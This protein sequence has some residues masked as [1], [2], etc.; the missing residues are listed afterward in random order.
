[1]KNKTTFFNTILIILT[2]PS[3]IFAQISLSGKVT[4]L[5][6]GNL[7]PTV[8]IKCSN[9]EESHTNPWGEYYFEDLGYGYYNFTFSKPYYAVKTIYN[10]KVGDN[11]ILNVQLSKPCTALKFITDTL[12]PASVGKPY[13]AAL[14][15]NCDTRPFVFQLLDSTTLPQG[16]YLDSQY[17]NISGTPSEEGADPF[18]IGVTDA[19][20]NFTKMEFT[21]TVTREIEFI[22]PDDLPIAMRGEIYREEIQAKHGTLPYVFECI[23]GSL[24]NGLFLSKD[25]KIGGGATIE[26]F[27]DKGLPNNWE[28]GDVSPAISNKNQLLFANLDI[29][30]N[31]VATLRCHTT[32]NAAIEFNYGIVNQ[33][34]TSDYLTF[35]V[36]QVNQG[37]FSG[38]STDYILLEG[39]AEGIHIF[40]WEFTKNSSGSLYSAA[41][42]DNVKIQGMNAVP[43]ETGPSNFTIRVTDT[44]G[45]TIKKTFH[46]NVIEPLRFQN[47]VLPIGIVG[48]L[49]EHTLSASGGAGSYSFQKYYGTLPQGINL[50]SDTGRLVGIPTKNSYGTVSFSVTDDLGNKKYLDVI[51]QIV[52]PLRI[53]SD[54]M[55]EGRIGETYSESIMVSGGIHPLS[56]TCSDSLPPG[57]TLDRKTGNI[58]GKPSRK[59]FFNVSVSVMDQN[60]STPPVNKTLS[61]EISDKLTIISSAILPKA[62]K[63]TEISSII[64]K[65]AGGI[66]P[67]QWYIK[68]GALPNGIL[69]DNNRG[70]LSGTPQEKGST[71]F[72]IS[73]EDSNGMTA[74][75]EFFWY[76]S[77]SLV[78]VTKSL[79]EGIKDEHYEQEIKVRGGYPPYYWR[80]TS[81][82]LLTNLQLNERTGI[83]S[84]TPV[85][86]NEIRS[87]TVEI[88]DSDT[89]N[90]QIKTYTFDM[91]SLSRKLYIVTS[92]LP[93]ARVDQMYNVMIEAKFGT[94]PYSWRLKSGNLPEGI[95]LISESLTARL[96]GKPLKVHEYG[97]EI[98]VT[99]SNYDKKMDSQKF[100]L[101]VQGRVIILNETLKP[102]CANQ[103]YSEK[104]EVSNGT[105]PYHFE[106]IGELPNMLQLNAKSGEITGYANLQTGE[107]AS[108][109]IKVTD[110]GD[111]AM[112]DKKAFVIFAMDCDLEILTKNLPNA[113][114]MNY[115]EIPLKCS[116]G[117][118]PYRFSLGS[119]S[120][121]P[122]ILLDSE[123]GK[124]SGIPEIEGSYRF[125][126]QLTDN[127]G[128]PTRQSYVLEVLACDTCPV[129][130]GNVMHDTG[131]AMPEAMLIIRDTNG[132]T[133]IAGIDENGYYETKIPQGWSGTIIPEKVGYN[134]IPPNR[135]YNQLIT[136][137]IQQDFEASII[138]YTISGKIM[139][140]NNGHGLSTIKLRYGSAGYA[141]VTNS[142]GMYSIVVPFG[143]SGII[144]PENSGYSFSPQSITTESIQQ[145]FENK[146]F[147]ATALLQPQIQVT[148]L[149]LIFK[150]P[151]ITKKVQ[152]N[153]QKTSPPLSGFG[154]G[155]IVPDDVI[156]HWKTHIP[157][158][159]YRKRSAI[160]DQKDWSQF[161]SPV[162]SQGRCGSC[163]AFSAV[164]L[165]ENLA[166]R[167]GL[168]QNIDL[169]EQSLLSCVNE[170][171]T[172]YGC[173]GG[174][175]WDALNFAKKQKIPSESCVPYE[176]QKNECS[177][178]DS[179]DY[180]ITLDNFT[181]S[182]GL[183][184]SNFSIQDLKG[185]L[186][187]GPLCV[188]MYVPDD[189]F[190]Y[191]GGI[192]D[193]QGG[194][195]S[196]G[197]AV[198]LVGYDDA[199]QCFK[200][201]NSWGSN[202]GEDGYFRIAYNDT[203][204][205]KFGCYA[206]NASGV[207]LYNQDQIVTIKNTGTASLD[208]QRIYSDC[209][210]L[211]FNNQDI[212]SIAPDSYKQLAVFVDWSQISE[213]EQTAIL[214]I[215]SNDPENNVTKI[216]VRAMVPV[217]SNMPILS[218][219]P[220]FAEGII[221]ENN[222]LTIT[223][224]YNANEQTFSISN[225]GEGNLIW[226]LLTDDQWITIKSSADGI[227]DGIVEIGYSAN[228]SLQT[229]T[230]T[231]TIN[232]FG[233]DDSPQY[234]QIVQD[235]L[236][237]PDMDH[238]QVLTISDVVRMLQV[239]AGMPE[240]IDYNGSVKIKN[241]IQSLYRLGK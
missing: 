15:I 50:E 149:S 6:T 166:N 138:H 176:A 63:N 116:G 222:M 137:Q 75:K 26:E 71:S 44:E 35:K 185:A 46:L 121:P 210:W 203:E 167:A 239:L 140:S 89:P 189:F 180:E 28:Y 232:A 217:Q 109:T 192:Y 120:L 199:L 31:S 183:W 187:D 102:I 55:P 34:N 195:M 224:D 99:D 205:I 98:E 188:A 196:F 123:N 212:S 184:G 58:M 105:L 160:P 24:P 29:N 191:S 151:N 82:S 19:L 157:D 134:F 62:Q 158:Y 67:F 236:S 103:D 51:F 52:D 133:R 154:T 72:T 168:V 209:P 64:L 155:L 69:L 179:P 223:S 122:G 53:I 37:H 16:L 118:L 80:I 237:F 1:M 238:D 230:G 61:I 169:S 97:F 54:H 139:D 77:D 2:L 93:L 206:G 7:I 56:F 200:A 74:Q 40:Q 100:M 153:Q 70:I 59:G 147:T 144:T 164:A 130:S 42:I 3:I 11:E 165:I 13:N 228:T 48:D 170:G 112:E 14:E 161:D 87:F 177:R 49:Y 90:A 88:S 174:W 143:W 79:S 91:M 20:N 128:I 57:L 27:F 125:S 197:H 146:N 213:I 9:G 104:I 39:L 32:S 204:D 36:D 178:C 216:T 66:S 221:V 78:F 65:A 208:I 145:D 159:S 12:P 190:R 45:R 76:I 211:K 233:A 136:N 175:Y 194:E 22:T 95:E 227:N 234:V 86:D 148:P 207:M 4:D 113:A 117:T 17:G 5:A 115:Y 152:S 127:T 85:K 96:Q 156:D 107:D 150:K 173:D 202:W 43:T 110:S 21:I 108:F 186:Q 182:Y 126:I 10:V 60:P 47:T 114:V 135:I 141:V 8:A 198:L 111:P 214:T 171:E 92:N 132:Y 94:P 68:E 25:G 181:P 193:F 38:N 23:A 81:G 106:V 41:W 241:V 101:D 163:W 220:P 162:R 226:N 18:T 30:Q 84:G 201:K 225:V 73:V 119:G 240:G 131:G 229:R 142:Q 129:I 215:N 218:I 235:S 124:L 172:N 231:I 219:S 83:I 33:A